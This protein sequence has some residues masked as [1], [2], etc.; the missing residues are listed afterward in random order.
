MKNDI[1]K[2]CNDLDEIKRN[3]ID[4]NNYMTETCNDAMN[5]IVM[6]KIE[7]LKDLSL[8]G[9]GRTTQLFN[10]IIELLLKSYFNNV[11]YQIYVVFPSYL[12]SKT[13]YYRFERIVNE[14]FNPKSIKFYLYIHRGF[15]FNNDRCNIEFVDKEYYKNNLIGNSRNLYSHRGNS[16]IDVGYAFIDHSVAPSDTNRVVPLWGTKND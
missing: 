5:E 14:V 15:K 3:I 8:K 4:R 6:D 1:E 12:A 11:T 7:N 2:I 10:N 16:N 13:Q 9:S